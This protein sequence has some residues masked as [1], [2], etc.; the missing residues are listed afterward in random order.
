MKN[1][2]IVIVT[3]LFLQNAPAYAQSAM[4]LIGSP[5]VKISEGGSYRL[6]EQLEPSKASNLAC[7]ITK[8]GDEY[9]WAS[10][11][12]IPLLRLDSGAF[13]TFIAL[14]GSGYVRVVKKDHKE[15]VS[16]MSETEQEFDYVEHLT[17]GLRSVTY[18]GTSQ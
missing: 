5:S 14:N 13:L 7:V 12:N 11:E 18:Y 8:V 15:I 2:L 6:P 4:V 16:L 10:R 17:I 1:A 9:L 3:V